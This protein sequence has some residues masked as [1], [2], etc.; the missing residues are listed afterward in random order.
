MKH[1]LL[2]TIAAALLVGTAFADPIHTAAI[3]GD[4]A[5]VQ[6]ELDKGVDVN[7]KDRFG[8]T[9]LHLAATKEIAELLINED[10]DVNAK[11]KGWTP[12]YHAAWRGHKEVAELLIAKGADVNMKDVEGVTPLH[13]AA[14]RGHTE[15]VELLITK[16][17]DVNAKCDEGETPLDWAIMNKQT[18]LTAL[19][20]KHCGKTGEESTALIDAAADGN[21]EVVK[22][23]LAAGAN[24]NAK[25]KW[26]GTP[27]HWAARGGHKEIVELLIA[28]GANVNAKND[29]DGTPLHLAADRGH[30]EVVE[31]LITAG[32]DV[33]AKDDEGET[34]LDQAGTSWPEIANLLRKHGGKTGEE[35]ALMPRLVQH[36]RF[37]FS[38]VAKKGKVYEVQDSFDLLN[39]EVIKTYTGTGTSV[40][41]D[42][43]R[44]HDPP[45]IFYCVKLVE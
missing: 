23:L 38:F 3:N 33:N 28:K 26:G 13:L 5:G 22:Q 25:N 2:T 8:F 6:A 42:E 39:W 21:I 7:V 29:E 14:D 20:R 31:L 40:R 32:A 11:D 12:L 10:A 34:P 45:Q 24:V 18:E 17:A 27:L 16:G 36:G 4:L 37:A 15:V 43:E 19:L 30:T 44:D 41:F 35:L 9:P 1:L